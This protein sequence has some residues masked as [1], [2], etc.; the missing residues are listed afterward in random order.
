MDLS[1]LGAGETAEESVLK[2]PAHEVIDLT[3]GSESEGDEE[4]V[5]THDLSARVAEVVEEVEDP[6][7]AG[8]S[9]GEDDDDEAWE[10]ESLF[11]DTI[12][13]MGDEHL[14]EGGR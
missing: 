2:A 14:L 7:G 11:E 5:A 12:Q 9:T 10:S 6:V 3:S 13:E 8:T 1:V 4:D